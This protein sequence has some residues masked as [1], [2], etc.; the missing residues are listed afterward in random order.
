MIDIRIAMNDIYK[1]LEPTLTKCGFRITT[2]ADISDG[3]PVE[4]TSGRA[5]M[6]FSGDNKALRIEHY[7]N[8]I[9]LLWAQKE[10]ANETDFAKIALLDV[11]TADDKDIKFISDEY[12]ELIEESFGK[13]GT[14]D[15]KKVKL[16]T[17]VSKAAAKSGEACYDANTFANRLSVIYPELRDEYRK[18]IET[19]GEFLPEDFFKNHAAPVVIK[20]IKENDPQKMRKLFNLLNEIY[21]D[22]TNEIQSI[23]AVTVL[24]ELNNDRHDLSCCPGQ[25]VSREVQ[26]RENEAR[27]SAEVQA[28]EEKEEKE[29]VLHPDE[30]VTSFL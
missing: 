4:V 13:N 12:A 19:Y 18:N 28:Q 21:D 26:E 7:D 15:K 23:I 3:I 20:V 8:K 30:S 27:K 17:P 11:E 1:N 2:P 16:P 6:D 10:G 22:G 24:G 5:V 9:A 29:H 14:A 25:Q